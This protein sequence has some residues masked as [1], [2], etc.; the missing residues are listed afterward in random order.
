VPAPPHRRR[1]LAALASCALLPSLVTS[2]VP[3]AAPPASASGGATLASISL[4][5]SDAPGFTPVSPSVETIK[6][7]DDQGQ[8]QAFVSCARGHVLLD[9]FDQGTDALESVFYGQGQDPYGSPVLNLASAVFGDG[10]TADAE[11]AESELASP[12]FQHCWAET[13]D[14]LNR[15]QGVAVPIV[16]STVTGLPSPHLGSRSSAFAIGSRYSALGSPLSFQLAVDVVQQGPFIAMLLGLAFGRTFPSPDQLGALAK[17][18]A[19]M[20][21][22]GTVRS[23]GACVSGQL[24][25]P[26]VPVLTDAQVTEDVHQ[27]V[28]LAS[29]APGPVVSCQ[30]DGAPVPKDKSDPYRHYTVQ[31]WFGIQFLTTAA[32]ARAAF[33]RDEAVA[34]PP[35]SVPGLGAVVSVMP[36]QD[37]VT[38]QL[39][40]MT[41]GDDVFT[42]ELSSSAKT[43]VQKADLVAVARQVLAR[44]AMTTPAPVPDCTPVISSVTPVLPENIQDITITG[45]CLGTAGPVSFA[46]TKF[47]RV[48]DSDGGLGEDNWSACSMLGSEVDQIKCTITS[49]TDTKVVLTAVSYVKPSL[50]LGPGVVGPRPVLCSREL[51]QLGDE[52][53]FQLWDPLSGKGP[54]V[55]RTTVAP[56][57]A[58][59]DSSSYEQGATLAAK[60][61]ADKGGVWYRDPSCWALRA[62]SQTQ[63]YFLQIRAHEHDPQF[64]LGMLSH[65]R[66][67]AVNSWR[68]YI[69]H[70]VTD[71][72]PWVPELATMTASA[73]STGAVPGALAPQLYAWMGTGQNGNSS[74]LNDA[75]LMA[76]LANN[77]AG[78]T[79]F[80][81]DLSFSQIGTWSRNDQGFFTTARCSYQN[82][83]GKKV[84]V[85]C[86]ELMALEVVDYNL[87][88]YADYPEYPGPLHIAQLGEVMYAAER[89]EPGQGAASNLIAPWFIDFGGTPNGSSIVSVAAWVGP[90]VNLN[91]AV[92]TPTGAYVQNAQDWLSGGWV[93]AK[94]LLTAGLGLL[95]APVMDA[96]VGWFG[97]QVA[98]VLTDD[99]FV[100]AFQESKDFMSA[101]QEGDEAGEAGKALVEKEAAIYSHTK[102]ILEAKDNFEALVGGSGGVQEEV[103]FYLEIM[104]NTF[105]EATARLVQEHI[106]VDP[107]GKEVTSTE[108]VGRI[109]SDP[110]G[111][112]IKGGTTIT[113][114][115]PLGVVWA[116]IWSEFTAT[117]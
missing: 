52:V 106:L 114:G 43:K 19:R 94:T 110:Q 40:A 96:M 92:A 71:G 15:Q 113:G 45:T 58:T 115:T 10:S 89:D 36:G 3:G 67:I 66:Q 104:V 49:W 65:L 42:V 4:R 86:F 64:G 109:V 22:G 6:D 44:L 98:A 105:F 85:Q 7:P 82:P 14:A 80:V 18:V 100:T 32:E 83:G 93:L 55:Y 16:P 26:S 112:T 48:V 20:G 35:Q 74:Q 88:A 54:A 90:L 51:L 2:V 53:V 95:L 63:Q 28:T 116:T 68:E 1:C 75:A 78:A 108:E 62:C 24:A 101:L 41:S 33:K 73:Y 117:H 70:G 5:A 50:C 107:E 37:E 84:G 9:R 72:D 79:F 57:A 29:A 60:L 8:S 102:D 103:K 77:A 59:E 69:D 87:M 25:R 76:A 56:D 81:R 13:T 11:A 39:A 27:K 17:M 30:W 111:Y 99:K 34:G 97:D 21:A 47:F 31:V 91:G 12:S 23:E 46:D 61:N 38:E